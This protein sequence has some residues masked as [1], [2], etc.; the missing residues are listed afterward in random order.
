MPMDMTEKAFRNASVLVAAWFYRESKRMA[1]EGKT[2]KEITERLWDLK[3]VL[4][5]WRGTATFPNVIPWE[6][7]SEDLE[8]YITE[9]KPKWLQE[10]RPR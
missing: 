9:Q 7:K 1:E 6:W 10:G 2:A 4:V 5:D 8:K 3:A